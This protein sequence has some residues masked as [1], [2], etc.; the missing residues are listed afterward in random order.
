MSLASSAR[1]AWVWSCPRSRAGSPPK[2]PLRL[3]CADAAR[4]LS[5]NAELI[6]WVPFVPMLLVGFGAFVLMLLDAFTEDDA[7]LATLS[8]V[9]LL[10]ASII[11]AAL[12]AG[13]GPAPAEAP[14]M[15]AAYLRVDGLSQYLNIVLCAGGGLSA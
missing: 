9:I 14:P 10:S 4:N 15:L 8:A 1:R 2:W 5:M 3:G 7:Q 12:A 13:L 11:A 6:P